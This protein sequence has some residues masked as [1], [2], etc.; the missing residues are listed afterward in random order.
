MSI[1]VRS[2]TLLLPLAEVES[3]H[4]AGR[5]LNCRT[6]VSMPLAAVMQHTPGAIVGQVADNL[7]HGK[8]RI[9]AEVLELT[10]TLAGSTHAARHGKVP[11]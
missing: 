1:P 3:T 4:I 2:S 11:A 10:R 5:C 8:D 7:A 6:H 9:V